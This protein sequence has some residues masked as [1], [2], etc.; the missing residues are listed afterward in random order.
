[1]EIGFTESDR[2]EKAAVNSI[3]DCSSTNTYTML[4]FMYIVSG[5]KQFKMSKTE[6]TYDNPSKDFCPKH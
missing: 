3:K 5:D 2:A 4:T 1:M 6:G